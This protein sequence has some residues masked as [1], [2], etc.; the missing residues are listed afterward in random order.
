MAL[1][2]IKLKKAA[3]ATQGG[4]CG[5]ILTD[6]DIKSGVPAN[7]YPDIGETDR[8]AGWD[9]IGKGFAKKETTNPFTNGWLINS[10]PT[11][12][13]DRLRIAGGTPTD[14]W[15]AASGY[16]AEDWFGSGELAASGAAGSA[17]FEADF[18]A[19]DG[20]HIGDTVFLLD[21][22]INRWEHFEVADL[23]WDG[24]RATVT[25]DGLTTNA[26]PTKQK[27]FLLGTAL[28]PFAFAE[29]DY[30]SIRVDG[31]TVVT[32][33]FDA[34]TTAAE[35]AATIN[36]AASGYVTASAIGGYL[37]LER[38]LYY[39]HRFFQCIGGAAAMTELGLSSAERRGSDGT[40][41]A[42]ALA[43]GDLAPSVGTVVVTSGTGGA[44]DDS[45]YPILADE[46]GGVDDDFIVTWLDAT[47][48]SISGT[49]SGA[50]V[51][52]HD[53]S[54][55]CAVVHWSGVYFTIYAAGFSG[56]FGVGDT[57]TFSTVSSSKGFWV[58]AVGPAACEAMDVNRSGLKVIGSV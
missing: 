38:D 57:M 19:A 5:G 44:Y 40:V 29:D 22:T 37:H 9:W 42:A 54:E 47:H 39:Y 8:V 24:T 49:R 3:V 45:G 26:Y 16:A 27:A 28:E 58:R 12:A 51:T 55:D 10:R 13:G 15:Y 4:S 34:E 48:Y 52:N 23:S 11:E 43:L 33:Y 6:D 50:I 32:A 56:T 35:V 46:A 1:P 18:E 25:I 41:V 36:L 2:V 53:M 31:K 21:R 20:I 7:F 17:V 30:L 14:V